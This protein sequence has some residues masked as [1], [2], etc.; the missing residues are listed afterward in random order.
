M[1]RSVRI[2]RALMGACAV[3]WLAVIGMSVAAVVA[4][5]ELGS[6]QATDQPE[7]SHTP[8]ALYV[9]IAISAAIII[10]SIPLLL[11]ARRAAVQEPP[12]KPAT[13]AA[14]PPV[15]RPAREAPTE[16]LRV[17]GSV[18]DPVS[19]GRPGEKHRRGEEFIEKVWQRFI[20][21]MGNAVGGATLAVAFATYCM[22]THAGGWAVA[23]LVVAGIIAV[24]MPLIFWRHQRRLPV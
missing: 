3:I 18:A 24:L 11:R 22:G 13:P 4:V 14:R 9:V 16:K 15:A 6:G 23:A 17:F 7:S 12:R 19:Q 20:V 1:N 8:W 21:S 5:V 2:D 10:A